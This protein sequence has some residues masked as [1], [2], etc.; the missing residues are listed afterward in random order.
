[1]NDISEPVG[2]LDFDGFDD[3]QLGS[4]VNETMQKYLAEI[5]TQAYDTTAHLPIGLRNRRREAMH[6]SVETFRQ[7]GFSSIAFTVAPTL[8]KAT[9]KQRTLM[10]RS[11][12]GTALG[13]V[14]EE[15]NKSLDID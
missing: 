7:M 1:M 13:I 8:S 10:L 9:G 6:S 2:H 4:Y 12:V 3:I 11:V 14:V 15:V 5:I